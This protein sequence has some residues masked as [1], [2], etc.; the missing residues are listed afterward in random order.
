MRAE[1]DGNFGGILQWNNGTT[2]PYFQGQCSKIKGFTGAFFPPK[3]QRTSFFFFDG[4]Y[5]KPLLLV[6]EE[7]VNVKGL[8]GLK[9]SGKYMFDNGKETTKIDTID[10]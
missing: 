1:N 3:P 5:C 7:D 9:F 4:S 10:S 8:P 6:Y 2:T